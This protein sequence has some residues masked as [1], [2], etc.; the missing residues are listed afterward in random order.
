MTPEPGAAPAPRSDGLRAL[1]ILA[2]MVLA[3]IAFMLLMQRATGQAGGDGAM[4]D[5]AMH[6]ARSA[7]TPIPADRAP[8]RSMAV[9]LSDFAFEPAAFEVARGEV[10]RF[11]VTNAGTV[12]HELR[13]TDEAEVERHLAEAHAGEAHA[14]DS[15]EPGVILLQPG[16]TGELV[17]AFDAPEQVSLVVCLIP[18]HY[19]SGMRADIHYR[20]P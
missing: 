8:D 19:E 12:E 17:W 6:A 20:D 3:G 14:P 18:G 5:E 10:I 11:V 15:T 13:L 16:E 9:T 2:L 7:A 4:A 1:G